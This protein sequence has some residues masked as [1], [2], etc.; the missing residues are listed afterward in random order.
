MTRCQEIVS[1]DL[2][3]H[4]CICLTLPRSSSPTVNLSILFSPRIPLCISTIYWSSHFTVGGWRAKEGSLLWF[5]WTTVQSKTLSACSCLRQWEV[6]M[7][8]NMLQASSCPPST[9]PCAAAFHILSQKLIACLLTSHMVAYSCHIYVLHL[10][11]QSLSI[12]EIVGFCI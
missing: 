3:L 9:H 8:V 6:H 10:I 12:R 4:V 2:L 7:F 5:T 1:L 11:M